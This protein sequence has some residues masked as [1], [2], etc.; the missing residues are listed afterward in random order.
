MTSVKQPLF[1]RIFKDGKLLDLKQFT[2]EQIVIGREGNVDALINDQSISPIHAMIE[3]R[4]G[5][6]YICDLGS[7]SGTFVNGQKIIDHALESGSEFQLGQI[8]F[9]FHIGV[10]KPKKAAGGATTV[11]APTP[12]PTPAA[13][14]PPPAPAAI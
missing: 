9:E 6:F 5:T 3:E 7:Q 4:G 12:A 11:A 10:P 8:H 1:L 14:A 2:G 13:P